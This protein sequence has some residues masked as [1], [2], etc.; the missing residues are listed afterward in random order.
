MK[1][2]LIA[3]LM[4]ILLAAVPATASVK[5]FN[6]TFAPL[7]VAG[8]SAT[9]HGIIGLEMTALTIP[10]RYLYDPLSLYSNY[11]GTNSPA[12]VSSLTVTVSGSDGGNGAFTLNKG[13]LLN[14]VLV[15]VLLDTAQG[16]NFNQEF[17]GQPSYKYQDSPPAW[18]NWGTD[19]PVSLE[20][21]P[22]PPSQSYT[23]DFQI[24]SSDS[25]LAPYGIYPYQMATGAG[26]P[27]QLTSFAAVPE[28]STYALFAVG[29]GGLA[30]LGRR[31][32]RKKK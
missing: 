10:G 7:G 27:M 1:R 20:G 11:G 22:P 32:S 23:G 31:K 16:V 30:L 9:A 15:A 5:Y 24:F 14:S 26:E 12:L 8:G 2:I 17:V 6:F 19:Q 29:L 25:S 18:W 21:T 13:D 4:A 3:G 28:P